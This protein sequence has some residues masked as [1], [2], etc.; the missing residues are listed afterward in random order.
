[1]KHKQPHTGCL[2][3]WWINAKGILMKAN[4][5]CGLGLGMG[6]VAA[7]MLSLGIGPI[8][9]LEIADPP[10]SVVPRGIVP[11]PGFE[12]QFKTGYEPGETT[13]T[14]TDA[15]TWMT[16]ANT[17]TREDAVPWAM[18]VFYESPGDV[19]DRYARLEADPSDPDNTVLH[20]WL[21]NATIDSGYKSHTKG[22]IQTGF[23]GHLVDA[24]EVY[25]SQRL[26]LHEDMN[27]LH[28]YPWNGDRWWLSVI[29]Q[30]LWSGAAW[31]GHP[32][33]SLI[34]LRMYSQGG[35]M[36][37]A[38]LC[39]TMPEQE[40]IWQKTNFGYTLPVGEWVTLEIGYK[41]GNAETGRMVVMVTPESTGVRETVFDVTDWTYDPAADEPGGTGPVPLTYWNPQKLYT[42]DNVVDFIRDS[43]GVAQVYWDDFAFSGEWP[44]QWK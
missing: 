18:S 21:K 34:S 31:E 41:M 38:L 26:F 5:C 19:T 39:Q 33:P 28:S 27:L 24:V 40:Q 42:S 20:Y 2:A 1:M 6:A 3:G 25:S 12:P 37:L 8:T 30:S 22:R 44:P 9:Q 7:M 15:I 36:R 10:L 13:G 11:Y 29:L 35:K 32:N 43:G 14:P 16:F 23:P 17:S 4:I